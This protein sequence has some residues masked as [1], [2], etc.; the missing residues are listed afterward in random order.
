MSGID[1]RTQR[2]HLPGARNQETVTKKT[3]ENCLKKKEEKLKLKVSG[4]PNSM[5]IF[6][7]KTDLVILVDGV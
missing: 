1:S 7:K 5:T 4:V 3:L 6:K 2:P